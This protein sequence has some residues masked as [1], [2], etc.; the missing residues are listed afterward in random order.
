MGTSARA[1][2]QKAGA[3]WAASGNEEEASKPAVAEGN[4]AA[5]V[6]AVAESCSTSV[7][8]QK[9]RLSFEGTA[10][11][12]RSATQQRHAQQEMAEA[13]TKAAVDPLENRRLVDLLLLGSAC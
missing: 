3:M 5:A 9:T 7:R 8:R 10:Y 2:T 6:E 13:E 12:Q 11:R 1:C 4:S